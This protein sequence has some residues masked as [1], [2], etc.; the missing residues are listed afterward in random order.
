MRLARCAYQP[1][2]HDLSGSRV[3]VA[4]FEVNIEACGR[5]GR[6]SATPGNFKTENRQFMRKVLLLELDRLCSATS[7]EP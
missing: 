1:C 5:E 2:A 3:D 7:Y 6:I 4:Q